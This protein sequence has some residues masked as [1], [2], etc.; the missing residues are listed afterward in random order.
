MREPIATTHLV[1]ITYKKK[2][3]CHHRVAAHRYITPVPIG[4]VPVSKC[5]GESGWPTSTS[6]TE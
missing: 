2:P 6:E 1:T 3:A 5:T 4:R